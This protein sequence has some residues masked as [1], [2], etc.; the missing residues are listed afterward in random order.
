MKSRG[1][2]V[3]SFIAFIA[4]V[5]VFVVYCWGLGVRT[6]KPQDRID[7]SVTAA[8]ISNLVVGSSVLLSGIPV[9]QVTDIS[10]STEQATIKFYVDGRY[11]I[12]VDSDIRFD[13]L[14][15]LGE[16]YIE[17]DPKSYGGANYRNGDRI[18]ADRLAQPPSISALAASVVRVLNQLDPDKLNRV[19]KETD[20]AM[21]ARD[22]VL[23]NWARTNLLLR[24]ITTDFNGQGRT[25]LDN[26]Q[27]LLQNAG[28]VG[29]ALAD[30]AGPLR[31]LGPSIAVP[32]N[33]T[34]Q[35]GMALIPMDVVQFGGLLDRIQ[36]FLDDRGVD[37]KILGEATS[38]NMDLI[39]DALGNLDGSQLMAKLLETVPQDGVVDLHV[40]A[41]G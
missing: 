24:N 31:A 11:E 14:S 23:P 27:T 10:T 37:L 20:S 39:A 34:W 8:D 15:A 40:Q 17:V 35:L 9:G 7:L 38:G 28:F 1:A 3:G 4:M 25:V 32:M 16:A 13:N 41:P 5:T 29:P 21:A 26:A 12:P 33:D 19:I 2:V 18:V 30:A 36:K 6:G 22:V